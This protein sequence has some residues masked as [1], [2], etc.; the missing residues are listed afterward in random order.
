MQIRREIVGAACLILLAGLAA[1]AQ[2]F[3]EIKPSPQQLEWQDMEMG[4]IVHFGLNTFT[5]KEWGDGTV[6]PKVFDPKQL[7]P[8]QWVLAAQS[9]GAKYLILVAKHHDGFCLFPSQRTKYSV[10][11]TPWKD[12]KGDLVKDVSEACKKHGLK[13]GVYLSPWDRHEPAYRVSA[14]YD[15][16]YDAQ[17]QELMTR[18]GNIVEFWLDGAGSEGHVYDFERYLRTLRTFQ[19]NTLVFAD[20]GF[21]K[22]GDIR[23]VGNEDGVAPEENWNVIDRLGYL[24]WRPAECDTPLR[25]RHWFWH[26]NDEKSLKSLSAL[27]DIYQQSVGRGA[28]LVLG[29]APDN[30]GLLPDSDVARLREFGE[31]FRKMYSKDLARGGTYRADV[32]GEAARAFDGDPD[33]SWT[34]PPDTHSATLE[35]A[36]SK[37]LKFDRTLVMEGLNWGQRIQKYEIQA[38]DG[39]TWKTLHAGSSIGHKKI[40]IFPAT[41]AS[42][43]RLRILMAADSPSVREF[44]VF[45]GSQ[46]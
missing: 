7:D 33:T 6:D 32:G 8:E 9:A 44:Q 41:T 28:Q 31:A 2:N 21:M 15:N 18:Y 30:R 10:A 34:A 27:L 40:D 25:E 23:W 46:P 38:W 16:F 19:P 1:L 3:S 45:D 12:G 43:V 17:L 24:R 22:Y 39:K 35:V 14:A 42:R 36:F 37:P 13:F 26:P 29:L 4:V 11:S 20:V 5:D